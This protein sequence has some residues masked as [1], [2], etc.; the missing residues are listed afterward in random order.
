M[1]VTLIASL[2]PARTQAARDGDRD[3]LATYI[4]KKRRRR[5]WPRWLVHALSRP[6]TEDDYDLLADLV[7]EVGRKRGRVFDAPAH[8]AARLARVLL[9]LVSGRIDARLR[10]GLIAFA[11]EI[12]GD[13]S[14]VKIDPERV[15]NLLDHPRPATPSRNNLPH[16]CVGDQSGSCRLASCR[17]SFAT[18]GVNVQNCRGARTARRARSRGRRDRPQRRPGSRR[19]RRTAAAAEAQAGPAP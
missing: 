9:S 15:R 18:R 11:C 5:L 19:R 10:T 8:R 4:A 1:T 7:A 3:R 13:E 16:I 17:F 6:P 14:G 2:L 12:E